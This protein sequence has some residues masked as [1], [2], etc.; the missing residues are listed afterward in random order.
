MSIVVKPSIYEI[1]ER[2]QGKPPSR[3][4]AI[5]SDPVFGSSD[6]RLL[7]HTP[8]A[9]DPVVQEATRSA[10]LGGATPSRLLHSRFEAQRIARYSMDVESWSGFAATR[11]LVMEGGLRDFRIIHFATHGLGSLTSP[12]L[13]GLLFTMVDRAGKQLPGF[14]DFE[15]ISELKLS[16][17]LVVLSACQTGIGPRYGPYSLLSPARAFLRAGARQVVSSLWQIDDEATSVLMTSFYRYMLHRRHSPERALRL[18][19]MHVRSQ[20]RW[21]APYYWAGFTV[22]GAWN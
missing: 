14:L 18:A 1:V 12:D 9:T 19:Q 22:Q 17:D 11:K 7:A 20:P 15:A 8:V 16:V 3:E 6:P 13:S 4:L 10:G 21:R 2:L 5:V